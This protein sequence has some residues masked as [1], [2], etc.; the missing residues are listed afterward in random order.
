MAGARCLMF[1]VII[2]KKYRKDEER[3]EPALFVL[4]TPHKNTGRRNEVII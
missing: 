1:D 2:L 4:L 3:E